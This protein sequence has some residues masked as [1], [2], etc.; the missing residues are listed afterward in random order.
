MIE[1]PFHNYFYSYSILENKDQIIEHCFNART[2]GAELPWGEGCILEK[3]SLEVNGF[4]DLLKPDIKKFFN[5][6]TPNPVQMTID[7][8]WMNTYRK[9]YFQEIHH[10]Q[11]ADISF[12]IFL[13]DYEKTNAEFYFYNETS[14]LTTCELHKV[15]SQGSLNMEDVQYLEPEKG[16]IVFFPSHMFHGVSA[17]RNDNVRTTVSGNIVIDNV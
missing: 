3:K 7:E 4:I 10:H 15:C 1:I 2:T 8:M 13:N 17:H 12:V 11:G 16:S 5:E 14:R 9:G 6:L